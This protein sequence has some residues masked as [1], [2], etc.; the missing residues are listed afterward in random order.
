MVRR[1]VLVLLASTSVP[2][3]PAV[4]APTPD[5]VLAEVV[6]PID[7]AIDGRMTAW[8]HQ[9]GTG[10][11]VELVVHDGRRVV[12]RLAAGRAAEDTAGTG[13]L[14]IGRDARGRAVV[15]Y[16]SCDGDR[17]CDLRVVRATGGPT[18]RIT[19]TPG[20]YFGEVAVGRGRVYWTTPYTSGEGVVRSRALTGGPTRREIAPG[21]EVVDSLAV[22]PDAIAATTIRTEDPRAGSNADPIAYHALSIARGASRTLKHLTT[23]RE[24][25]DSDLSYV[26]RGYWSEAA[27][28][29]GGMAALL[30]R[31][32]AIVARELTTARDGRVRTTSLGMPVLGWDADGGRTAFVEAASDSGCVHYVDPN[33]DTAPLA[34][35]CRIVRTE[36]RDA[37]RLLPPRISIAGRTATVARAVLS[38]GRVV[39]R[40]PQ[41]GVVVTVTDLARKPVTTLTTDAKGQVALPAA[42]ASRPTLLTA[43]TTPASYASDTGR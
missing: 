32:S 23:S 18:T 19:R 26:G 11:A 29:P 2:V 14:D 43:A 34:A 31:W 36:R 39:R 33:D 42:T 24:P 41:P 25:G 22:G 21:E 12:R 20:L 38:G 15:A 17:T 1:L 10:R 27:L 3:A 9:P 40:V 6:R 8:L 5:R 28:V 16:I 7:V 30:Y 37:E 13:S 4:A 35:P